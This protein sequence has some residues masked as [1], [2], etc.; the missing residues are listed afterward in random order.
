[1]LI[2]TLFI[3]LCSFCH[4]LYFKVICELTMIVIK[5]LCYKTNRSSLILVELLNLKSAL[6]HKQFDRLINHEPSL[7]FDRILISILK[8]TFIFCSFCSK[9]KIH[10][11]DFT[12][13]DDQY[14]SILFW[15]TL[16]LSSLKC[17]SLIWISNAIS[18]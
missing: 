17:D 10:C 13:C 15:Q 6:T 9:V 8:K 1:M 11:F 14:Y 12:I 16:S 5:D 18:F 3:R 7:N 4:V 2:V